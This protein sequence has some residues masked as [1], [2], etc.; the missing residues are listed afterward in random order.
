MI[1][2]AV[3]S[4]SAVLKWVLCASVGEV[5]LLQLLRFT[6]ELSGGPYRNV[7]RLGT[8]IEMMH[9]DDLLWGF[10]RSASPLV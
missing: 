8:I 5:G 3:V 10:G 1:S 4:E 2:L 9:G 7:E 6:V